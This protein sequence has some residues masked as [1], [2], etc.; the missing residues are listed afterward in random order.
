MTKQEELMEQYHID[1]LAAEAGGYVAS[2][3]KEGLAYTDLFFSV[4]RQFGIR[5][6]H[7]TPK[8]RCFVEEVTRVT[9]AIQQGGK[10]GEDVRPSFSA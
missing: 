5:Y 9:W 7:A 3:T 4:C 1:M 10:V 2:P 6:N 8:E